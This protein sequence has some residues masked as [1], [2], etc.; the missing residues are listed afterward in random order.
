MKARIAPILVVASALALVL[1]LG[2]CQSSADEVTSSTDG[3]ADYTSSTI[4]SEST[5]ESSSVQSSSSVAESVASTSESTMTEDKT[6]GSGKVIVIDPGH[7]AQ[8]DSGQEPVGPGASETKARVSDGTAGVVSGVSE[9]EVNLA[10][11]LKLRDLLSSQGVTVIMCRDTQDIDISNS[12]RASIANEAHA[13]LFVRLH[14]DGVDD[15]SVSGALMLV[16]GENEW[17]G[18]IV[19]R[20][21]R[22][23]Q[24]VQNAIIGE[25]GANDRG[26]VERTDL[27]GFNWCEVPTILPE[28]GCM[29]NPTEDEKLTSD[30]YQ[31]EL[32]Q[33]ICNGIMAY[34]EQ[35]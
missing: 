4:A 17:T 5:A 1:T 3:L 20:S 28:M 14:C 24:L 27:S 18:P 23:G 2:G 34:L 10:V 15:S 6:R 30:S 26:I 21:A 29:S 31:Q 35:E 16:P 33:G 9:S 22:A 32:A 11:G 7:Q 12:E 19:E 13:D 8:G 25:T